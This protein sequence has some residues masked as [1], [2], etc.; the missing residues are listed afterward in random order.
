MV[1]K[2]S[3]GGGKNK[4]YK[5]VSIF[6]KKGFLRGGHN[7]AKGAPPLSK[8]PRTPLIHNVTYVKKIK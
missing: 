5:K 7:V 2:T 4:I 1:N 3:P 6:F 8:S